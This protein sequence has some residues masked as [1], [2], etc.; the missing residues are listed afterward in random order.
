MCPAPPVPFSPQ[1]NSG[2]GTGN[3]D[4]SVV[5]SKR[6][7]SIALQLLVELPVLLPLVWIST[8]SAWRLSGYLSI[9]EVFQ[10][11]LQLPFVQVIDR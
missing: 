10:E 3:S 7:V 11:W 5:A 9:D 6:V 4:P 2:G 8:D 1:G